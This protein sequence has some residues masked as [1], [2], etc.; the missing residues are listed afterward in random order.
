[1]KYNCRQCN[2]KWDGNSDTFFKV[3]VHEKTHEK[4]VHDWYVNL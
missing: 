3:L 4:K 2:F 1:M